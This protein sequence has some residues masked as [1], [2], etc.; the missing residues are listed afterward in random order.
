MMNRPRP[1]IAGNANPILATKPKKKGGP[2]EMVGNEANVV[3]AKLARQKAA[4]S[5][6]RGG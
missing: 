5:M 4:Q 3:P 2:G 1:R 6:M